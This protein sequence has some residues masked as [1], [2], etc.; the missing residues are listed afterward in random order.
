MIFSLCNDKKKFIYE[1]VGIFGNELT[2]AEIQYWC[3]FN[4]IQVAKFHK[5]EY[6]GMSWSALNDAI[7]AKEEEMKRE[8]ENAQKKR[9]FK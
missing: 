5:I 9:N 2:I 4:T 8:R 3:I 6:L 1:V 7:E